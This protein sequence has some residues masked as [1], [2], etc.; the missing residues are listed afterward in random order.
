MKRADKVNIAFFSDSCE[1]FES[2][3]RE[4]YAA[5]DVRW[6]SSY[7]KTSTLGNQNPP[8]L[9]I[10]DTYSLG[11]DFLALLP[12]ASQWQCPV[13]VLDH[14]TERLFIEDILNKGARG[15]LLVH[16]F[17]EE[18]SSAIRHLLNGEAYVSYLLEVYKGNTYLLK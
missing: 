1:V 16:S 2:I 17:E 6:V 4:V 8:S 5:C 7:T 18:L 3:P 10:L 9:I 15:Y 12:N 11:M 14:Y 13:L